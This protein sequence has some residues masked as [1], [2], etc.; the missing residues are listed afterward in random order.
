MLQ[1]APRR[2]LLRPVRKRKL[3]DEMR[4]DR[5]VSIR[6]A[7]R[8]FLVDTSTTQVSSPPDRLPWNNASKRFAK[9]ATAIGAFH[10][11]LHREGWYL[12]QNKT[13]ASIE[14]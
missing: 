12:G 7:C 3:V 1:D 5:D 8:V 2:K 9:F 6:R 11:L 14:S 4:G 13:R 10:V